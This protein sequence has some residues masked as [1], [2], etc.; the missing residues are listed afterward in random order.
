MLMP[1]ALDAINGR[2]SF[3]A[4]GIRLDELT[5]KLGGGRRAVRRP[6]RPQ[7]L[8]AGRARL[9][10]DRH[11]DAPALPGGVHVDHR[12]RPLP[13]RR[14]QR[15]G[16]RRHR[17]RARR[18]L[19]TT[20][21]PEL[22]PE[23]GGCRGRGRRGAGAAAGAATVPLRFDIQI[24]A[25]R[26]LRVQNN[27][28]RLVASANLT[29]AGHLRPSAALRDRAGRSRRPRLRRQPVR[30]HARHDRLQQ[31]DADRAV[32][33]RR[34]RNARARSGRDLPR[35]DR[36]HRHD[37]ED[38]PDPRFRSAALRGLDHLAAARADDEPAE[39]RI[40]VHGPG[41]GVARPAGL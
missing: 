28:A 38:G 39:C 24:D 7:R 6:H 21:R 33:R 18:A 22:L 4:A 15:A 11:P 34:G 20:D 27:L 14:H 41:G 8:R 17:H 9:D 31:P 36:P 3:D 12:R 30:D 13:A 16:A 19:R 10:G 32:F 35:H 26:S 5:A 23:P 25:P 29:A 1:H 37:R 2:L 40:A